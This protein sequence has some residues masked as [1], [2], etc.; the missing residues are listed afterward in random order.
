MDEKTSIRWRLFYKSNDKLMEKA[1]YQVQIKLLRSIQFTLA[2][3]TVNW[4]LDS[5]HSI[6]DF[7]GKYLLAY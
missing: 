7:I 1:R 3:Q 4:Y 2:W 5:Y 6:V